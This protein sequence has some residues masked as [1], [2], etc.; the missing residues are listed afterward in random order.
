[1]QDNSAMESLPSVP[2]WHTSHQQRS[3]GYGS[4]IHH[5]P[6]LQWLH[7]CVRVWHLHT[8][9]PGW[10]ISSK[11]VSNYLIRLFWLIWPFTLDC[12]LVLFHFLRLIRV[13]EAGAAV[14]SRTLVPQFVNL[15][16]P[17]PF[18]HNQDTEIPKLINLCQQLI[19]DLEWSLH[20][21]PADLL[22]P[23]PGI[24]VHWRPPPDE[25]SHILCKIQRWDSEASKV[26]AYHHMAAPKKICP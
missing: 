19:P 7:F 20:P 22:I 23:I 17:T 1:M 13:R 3:G 5:W 9:L 12:S 15:L 25:H 16:F 8:P 26:E 4:Q 24:P 10:S 21:F 2:S 6:H 18:F 14:Q 11:L